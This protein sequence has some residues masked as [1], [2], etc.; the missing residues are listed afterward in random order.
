V[1]TCTFHGFTTE[2]PAALCWCSNRPVD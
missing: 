2:E 1:K